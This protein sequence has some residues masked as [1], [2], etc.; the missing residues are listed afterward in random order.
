MRMSF[1]SISASEAAN[2][3]G[4]RPFC[5]ADTRTHRQ[6]RDLDVPNVTT[7]AAQLNEEV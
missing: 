3:Q 1:I 5:C 7:T 2:P 4:S 6:R